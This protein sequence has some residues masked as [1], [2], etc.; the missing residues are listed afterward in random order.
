MVTAEPSPSFGVAD[1]SGLAPA[2]SQQAGTFLVGWGINNVSSA[3]L[4]LA[5][6]AIP[7]LVGL[8]LVRQAPE[9]RGTALPN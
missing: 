3:A 1:I 6:T 5:L 8:V 4:P 7:F 9:T 2:S